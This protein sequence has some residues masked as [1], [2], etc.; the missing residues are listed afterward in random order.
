MPNIPVPT[1]GA[2]GALPATQEDVSNADLMN[3]LL[4]MMGGIQEVVGETMDQRLADFSPSG[5]AQEPTPRPLP[6]PP[7]I[8]TELTALWADLQEAQ[9]A[10]KGSGGAGEDAV[11]RA[12]ERL[13]RLLGIKDK[14]KKRTK[15]KPMEPAQESKEPET[16]Q[17]APISRHDKELVQETFAMVEPIADT[18][19]QIFYGRLFEIAPDL[20]SLFK[21][22]LK[23]QGRKLMAM[24]KKAVTGLDDL[25][26]L[27]PAVKDLGRRHVTYG[28][29]ETHYGPVADALLW[30]LQEGL[31]DAFTPEVREA[32][33]R[34]YGLLAETMQQGAR[35]E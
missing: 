20:R 34:V 35:E 6:F 2:K 3:V 22:D 24:I 8:G 23:D 17:E 1:P 5:T 33:T 30:T 26:T 16:P 25:E 18:A 15:A 19:A 32:W 21:T 4:N 10:L 12:T 14:K 7:S 27:V 13:A 28:V 29:E 11:T 31:R 9:A